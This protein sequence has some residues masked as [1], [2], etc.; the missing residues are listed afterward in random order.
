MDRI[1]ILLKKMKIRN[2]SDVMRRLLSPD[3]KPENN[4]S[5]NNNVIWKGKI[6]LCCAYIIGYSTNHICVISGVC[7]LLAMHF[8]DIFDLLYLVTSKRR[9]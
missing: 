2:S 9:T 5:N 4:Y 7:H 8:S 6:L 1:A 3:H